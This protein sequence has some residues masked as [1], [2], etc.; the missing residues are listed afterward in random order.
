MGRE[1]LLELYNQM[2]D[3]TGMC[4]DNQRVRGR[5][6]IKNHLIEVGIASAPW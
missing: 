3:N 4:Y 1:A 6:E 5:F 2:V